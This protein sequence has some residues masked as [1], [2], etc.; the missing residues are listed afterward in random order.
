[1]K[2]ANGTIWFILWVVVVPALWF[3]GMVLSARGL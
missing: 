1:M 2:R 3:L